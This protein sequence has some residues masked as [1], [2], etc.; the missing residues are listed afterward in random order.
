[1]PCCKAKKK[2]GRRCPVPARPCGYCWV[3][4]P[5][6]AGKRA[7]G[8]RQ[9][10]KTRSKPAAVLPGDI[11]DAPLGSVTDVTGFLAQA[12]NQVRKGQLD[13]KVANCCGFLV[14]VLL[15]AIEGGEIER[16][17]AALEAK[18]EGK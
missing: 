5:E 4:D 15:R 8:R 18:L 7:G 10:G 2:D 11:P 9:G 1:M 6:L 12:I 13:P 17:F 3:H 16:R 14:T